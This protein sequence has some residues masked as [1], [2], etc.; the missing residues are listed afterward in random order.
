MFFELCRPTCSA[1]VSSTGTYPSAVGVPKGSLGRIRVGQQVAC[2]ARWG[3]KVSRGKAL[4]ES[5]E[6]IFRGDFRLKI[7]FQQ[8]K[9][10]SA[11]KGELHVQ[12]PEGTVSFH[13]GP[14]ADVWAQKI[15]H[16]KS[17]L[18]KLGVKAGA[19]VC[20]LGIRDAEFRRQLGERISKFAGKRPRKNSDLIFFAAEQT[21]DV[22]RLKGLAHYLKK[23]GAVWVV[24]P[25]GQPHITEA[26]VMAAGK[27]AGL[28]D[29]KVVSF[30]AAH[31]A[32][33]LVIPVF[34]R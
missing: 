25:K 21:G 20:V 26:D 18:D 7:P 4:L 23:N 3:G 29:V 6:L 2:T 31:T 1:T 27:N 5:E 9:S 8:M 33:K 15:L 14:Q 13:L 17:F 10:V 11:A 28:V 24:Y 34:R 12:F 22:A 32:L 19:E 30:S 16:P